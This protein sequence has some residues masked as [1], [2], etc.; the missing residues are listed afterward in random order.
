VVATEP[1]S[2]TPDLDQLLQPLGYRARVRQQ[3]RAFSLRNEE[4]IETRFDLS[5][6]QVETAQA[7]L[8]FLDVV[9]S[10]CRVKSFEV[11]SAGEH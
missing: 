1:G 7:S 6:R 10:V 11:V 2:R 8:T 9:E 3:N 4:E 5:W